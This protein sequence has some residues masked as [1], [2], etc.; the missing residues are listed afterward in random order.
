MVEIM[1][2]RAEKEIGMGCCGGVCG[3]GFIEMRDEFKHHEKDRIQLGEL[4]QYLSTKFGDQIQIT[5]LDPRNVLI[6][7]AY[8]IKQWRK[9]HITFLHAFNNVTRQIK[10]NAI[11]VNGKYSESSAGCDTLVEEMLTLS[12]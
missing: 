10:Y 7:G 2:L 8:F 12:H 9:G 6:I 11:F 4:Y 3:E 1:I 5:Y